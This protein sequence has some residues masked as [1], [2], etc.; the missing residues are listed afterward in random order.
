MKMVF[1]RITDNPSGIISHYILKKILYS[2]CLILFVSSSVLVFVSFIQYA[3]IFITKGLDIKSFLVLLTLMYPLSIEFSIPLSL[4]ASLMYVLYVIDVKNE[5]LAIELTGKSRFTASIPIALFSFFVF[6]INLIVT[7]VVLPNTIVKIKKIAVGYIKDN[8]ID[9]LVENRINDD[10]PDTMIFF[11]KKGA[12]NSFRNLFIFQNTE[13]KY[14]SIYYA[15]D[16]EIETRD[17][18]HSFDVKM[19]SGKVIEPG[20][21][22]IKYLSF[23]SGNFPL[24]LSELIEKRLKNIRGFYSTAQ[25]KQGY[26]Y[27]FDG[28]YLSMVNIW[29]GILSIYILIGRLDLHRF[30]KYILF[31]FSVAIYYA[32]FRLYH[33]FYESA[34]M[35]VEE[36]FLFIFMIYALFIL[37]SKR[38]AVGR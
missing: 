34:F 18:S 35:R 28:I 16:A 31:F 17:Q 12:N 25:D 38:M 3:D 24:D 30:I 15:R 7:E 32:G 14:N 22:S 20:D 6:F 29:I 9:S 26:A 5:L 33:S 21:R 1:R 23:I 4:I 27:L 10:I 8:F 2:F 13:S 36:A 19:M 37:L 11:K